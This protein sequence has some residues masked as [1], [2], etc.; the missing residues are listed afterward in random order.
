MG[1]DGSREDLSALLDGELRETRAREVE[2]HLGT[3]PGCRAE[4]ER[5]RGA[6]AAVRLA[7]AQ[8]VPSTLRARVLEAARVPASPRRRGRVL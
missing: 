7:G 2:A 5:L 4:V 8:A 1:C 3:C 6:D